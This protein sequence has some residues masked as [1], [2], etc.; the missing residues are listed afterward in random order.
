MAFDTGVSFDISGDDV[1]EVRQS[2]ALEAAA[3]LEALKASG[4]KLVA[5][6]EWDAAL[7]QYGKVLDA[8]AACKDTLASDF[9]AERAAEKCFLAC[10]SNQALCASN[11]SASRRRKRSA[12]TR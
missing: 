8:C 12:G 3:N 7:K 6:K 1:I 5:A 9:E 2:P 4:A 11:C 10:L